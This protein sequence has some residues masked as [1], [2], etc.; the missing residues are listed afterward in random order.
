MVLLFFYSVVVVVFLFSFFCRLLLV[1]CGVS[2]R[3]WASQLPAIDVYVCVCVRCT[4]VR[5]MDGCV[6]GKN[7][8]GLR[9]VHSFQ[10]DRALCC[11]AQRNCFFDV[12][13]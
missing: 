7:L 13:P 4:A 1:A 11:D 9:V 12:L 2:L 10:T 8:H 5:P 6:I 3:R